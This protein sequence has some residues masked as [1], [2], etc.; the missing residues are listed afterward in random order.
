MEVPAGIWAPPQW[1]LACPSGL[2]ADSQCR[3]WCHLSAAPPPSPKSHSTRSGS[4]VVGVLIN[5][6]L[7]NSVISSC[8]QNLHRALLC[9]GSAEGAADKHTIHFSVGAIY[10]LRLGE[11][12]LGKRAG[13]LPACWLS[14]SS[15][16]CPLLAWGQRLWMEVGGRTNTPKAFLQSGLVAWMW[17]PLLSLLFVDCWV[18]CLTSPTSASSPRKWRWNTCP[19]Y[20]M[21]SQTQLEYGGQA[22]ETTETK[23]SWHH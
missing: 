20:L 23:Y 11:G 19:G 6:I 8:L 18:V 22:W 15:P 12:G 9:D 1:L 10:I 3:L 16:K 5:F 4:F 17:V 14:K 2:W 21:G 13:T 7:I